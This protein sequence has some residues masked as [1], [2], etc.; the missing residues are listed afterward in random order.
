MFENIPSI[1]D[2]FAATS[3]NIDDI[4]AVTAIGDYSDVWET[5]E[6][7]REYLHDEAK[8]RSMKFSPE[9][10]LERLASM[11]LI[12][13]T[14][15]PNACSLTPKGYALITAY[16]RIII[17]KTQVHILKNYGIDIAKE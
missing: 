6:N 9:K 5:D 12:K 7:I 2:L 13:R 4:Y 3:T 15:K 11:G 1:E 14:Q 17:E 16:E 10:A 8:I